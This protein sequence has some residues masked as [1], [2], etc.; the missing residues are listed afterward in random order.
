MSVSPR[1]HLNNEVREHSLA[2]PAPCAENR[3]SSRENTVFPN[4]LHFKVSCKMK[5]DPV[6]ACRD[7]CN[8]KTTSLLATLQENRHMF[9]DVIY[10]LGSKTPCGA[11]MLHENIWSVISSR[12][13]G[14]PTM[15]HVYLHFLDFSLCVPQLKVV[16]VNLCNVIQGQSPDVFAAV[17]VIK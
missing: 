16:K 12:C 2:C 5:G 8:G 3:S 14:S 13:P 11:E 17:V 10:F 1:R 4:N 7:R 9:K 15:E 6:P